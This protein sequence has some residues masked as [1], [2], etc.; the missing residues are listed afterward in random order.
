MVHTP[1]FGKLQMTPYAYLWIISPLGFG[2]CYRRDENRERRDQ[3]NANVEIGGE[4]SFVLMSSN[5]IVTMMFLE[6]PLYL[7]KVSLYKEYFYNPNH[8]PSQG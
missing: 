5:L 8:G 3:N 6:W 1:I 2:K 4:D 7:K